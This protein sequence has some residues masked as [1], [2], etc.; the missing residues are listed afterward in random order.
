MIYIRQEVEE[1]TA[2]NIIETVSAFNE[3][4]PYLVGDK[5]RVGAYHYIST[6]GTIAQPNIGKPPLTNLGLAWVKLENEPSNTYAC[7]DPYIDT[8][9]TWVKEGMVRFTRGQKDTLGIGNFTAT[10]IVIQYINFDENGN[11]IPIDTETYT[12]SNNSL[13]VDE[14]TYGYANFESET[15]GLVYF[16]LKQK[17]KE[18]KV[19]FDNNENPTDCGFLI[20]GKSVYMGF[21]QSGVNFPDKRIGTKIVPS[22]NFTTYIEAK[23]LMTK[24]KE[25]KKLINETLLFI[26]DESL[27]SNYGN[28]IFLGK[29]IIIEG[30]E[31]SF[32]LNQ[33]N[34]QVEQTILE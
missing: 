23:Q 6:Y 34:W 14:W 9:T 1:F 12:Y 8:K 27:E 5:C 26:V 32:T 13:V 10:Q 22:A 11:E 21:T 17:G 18:I 7:L 25:A 20:A 15:N 31:S 29:A 16:P 28:M 3:S 24:I 2:T 4:T 33:I 19:Y 30:S